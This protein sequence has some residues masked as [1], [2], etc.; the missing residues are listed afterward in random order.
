MS[1]PANKP[2]GY[3][4]LKSEDQKEVNGGSILGLGNDNSSNTIISQGY[5]SGSHTDD[6]GQTSSSSLGYGNGSMFSQSDKS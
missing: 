2:A 3:E 5:I 1:T 4:E 6:D